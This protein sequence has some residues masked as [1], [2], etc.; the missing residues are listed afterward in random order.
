MAA[1]KILLLINKTNNDMLMKAFNKIFSM[2]ANLQS[3]INGN[4]NNLIFIVYN[5]SGFSTHCLL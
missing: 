4:T 3:F 5:P 1:L 2:G